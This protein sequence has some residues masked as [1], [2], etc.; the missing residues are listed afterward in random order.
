MPKLRMG[1]VGGGEGAFIGSCTAWRRR[2]RGIPA[3]DAGFGLMLS[4]LSRE[5]TR[6]ER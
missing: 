2:R 3:A 4:L 6:I 1:M 5:H